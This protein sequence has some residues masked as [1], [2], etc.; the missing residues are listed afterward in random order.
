MLLLRD[1]SCWLIAVGRVG[2]Q[3]RTVDSVSPHR[4]ARHAKYQCIQFMLLRIEYFVFDAVSL[5]FT[6]LAS[7]VLT[8]LLCVCHFI[9]EFLKLFSFSR[10]D[11]LECFSHRIHR[12][13]GLSVRSCNLLDASFVTSTAPSGFSHR[14]CVC[15]CAGVVLSWW[16]TVALVADEVSECVQTRGAAVY[17]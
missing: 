17:L 4:A 16:S 3:N 13:M 5:R 14:L 7:P 2:Q 1:S 6:S 8:T 15:C 12:R 10:N 9:F 11:N